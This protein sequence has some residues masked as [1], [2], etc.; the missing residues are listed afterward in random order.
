MNSHQASLDDQLA[1]GTRGS[2]GQCCP[3]PLHTQET[4]K[5]GLF[6]L[7]HWQLTLP[8]CTSYYTSYIH[9]MLFHIQNSSSHISNDPKPMLSSMCWCLPRLLTPKSPI[10][11]VAS[12]INFPSRSFWHPSFCI[13]DHGY[14]LLL[15]RSFSCFCYGTWFHLFIFFIYKWF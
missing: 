5:S 15:M 13:T 12:F 4:Q 14:R 1:L 10:L 7:K 6:K 8:G 3:P 2:Q 11:W 9:N